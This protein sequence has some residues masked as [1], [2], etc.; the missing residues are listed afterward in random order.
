[1]LQIAVIVWRVPGSTEVLATHTFPRRLRRLSRSHDAIVMVP[2][3]DTMKKH[4]THNTDCLLKTTVK[5]RI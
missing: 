3:E 2:D 1:M 4:D 5:S